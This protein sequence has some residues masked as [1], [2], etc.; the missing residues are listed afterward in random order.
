MIGY[1]DLA[2]CRQTAADKCASEFPALAR[3]ISSNVSHILGAIRHGAHYRGRVVIVNYYATNYANPADVGLS[4][5][6]NAAVD[7]AAKPFHV[8]I[9]DGF[10]AFAAAALPFGGDSCAAGLLTQLTGGGC[11]IHPSAA[12]QAL[13][14]L[15][16]EQ[17]V[18]T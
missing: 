17:V 4:Q 18:K 16:V 10:G 9:A 15:A 7:G 14:A 6:L 3:E 11:G 1:N 8:R 13:L 12:G 5:G 2:L